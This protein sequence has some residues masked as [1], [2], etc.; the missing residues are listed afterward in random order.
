MPILRS[1]L[2]LSALV[3]LAAPLSAQT[4]PLAGDTQAPQ[5]AVP[6]DSYGGLIIPAA[7]RGQLRADPDHAATGGVVFFDE[8]GWYRFMMPDGGTSTFDGTLW[9]FSF[10]AG[11]IPTTCFAVRMEERS[12]AQFP[13]PQIQAELETLY[14]KFDSAITDNGFAID[15]RESLTLGLPGRR[16]ALP[17]RLLGWDS[18]ADSGL[19]ATWT[20]MPS[21][22]GYLLFACMGAEPAHQRE[23]IQKYLTIGS[24]MTSGK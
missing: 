16:G 23:V 11:T 24:V 2:V 7:E 3:A 6:V 20:L 15:H 22:I 8:L 5:K 13:M 17:L 18:H 19:R 14:P 9:Q 21:Q 12:L 1:S 4:N 10:P